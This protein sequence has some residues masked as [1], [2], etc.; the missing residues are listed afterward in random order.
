[1]RAVPAIVALALSATPAWPGELV[2]FGGRIEDRATGLRSHSLQLDYAE[3]LG[4]NLAYGLS[5][6]NEGHFVFHHRDGYAVQLRGRVRLLDHRLSLAAGVGPYL[7]FDTTWTAAGPTAKT[8]RHGW[9]VLVSASAAW[10]ADRRWF[11]TLRANRVKARGA[12]DTVS[13]LLG[14][15]YRFSAPEL[16]AGGEPKP[17]GDR[18][19][20]GELTIF[21]G[22][23]TINADGS[24]HSIA[25]G[26]EYRRPLLEHLEA[27]VGYL[28]E[29]RNDLTKRSGVTAQL[30]AVTGHAT[31]RLSFGVG[32]G[33]YVAL[34]RL[35]TSLHGTHLLAQ[36][37][38]VAA[39][40]RLVSR[41]TARIAWSRVATRYDRDSDVFVG[42]LGY[43][44]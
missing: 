42:G 40:F 1:M 29:G 27:T 21:G 25:S 34:D 12:F 11:L 14:I 37:V 19:P 30:W 10:D 18:P 7:A 2:L 4:P 9:G 33:P 38:T 32:G 35:R 8:D 13:G 31:G 28:N 26:V 20:R 23:S 16:A 3:D 15:G 5:Y 17:P 41:C 44:L 6:L 43:A 39:A 24:R 36:I 22:A